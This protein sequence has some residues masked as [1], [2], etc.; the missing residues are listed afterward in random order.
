MTPMT[1][2]LLFNP[3]PESVVWHADGRAVDAQD[4]VTA[5]PTEATVAALLERGA[6][7]DQGPVDAEVEAEASEPGAEPVEVL[8]DDTS[9]DEPAPA[10]D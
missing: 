7:L 9:V 8:V 3:G 2:H 6:L 4:R 1:D 10:A 5:D